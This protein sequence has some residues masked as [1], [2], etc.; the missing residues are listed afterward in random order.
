MG[1]RAQKPTKLEYK[2]YIEGTRQI[3]EQSKLEKEPYK[4]VV[5]GREF[6][7]YPNVF[8]PKYF[9]DTELFAQNL[10]VQNGE[11]MLEIGSGT[12]AISIS[13]I[14]KGAKRIVA[15]DINPDAVKNTQANIALHH[16]EDTVEIREGNLYEPLKEREF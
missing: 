2:D 7:V 9:H 5:S 14:Y 3:L 16:M 12:G 11:E 13:A 1:T 10:P 8:S 15:T 6:I 4:T